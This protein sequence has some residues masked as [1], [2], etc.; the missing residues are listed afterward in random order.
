MS[1]AKKQTL[2]N[3]SGQMKLSKLYCNKPELFGPIEFN[4]GL[5]VVLAE[6]RLPKNKNKDTHN[7]GKTTLV[8]L[9]NFMLLAKR[10]SKFFLFK[11]RD[12]FDEFVFFLEIELFDNLYITVCRSVKNASKISFRK[13]EVGRQNFTDLPVTEWNH[14][15]VPFEK[16]S[17]ILDGLLDLRAFNPWSFRKGIGYLL[18]S[19]EDYRDVFQLRKF[20]GDH[21]DWKPFLA[22]LLGFNADLLTSYYAKEKHI[23]ENKT[24]ELVIKKEF[25]SSLEDISKIEGMLLLKQKEIEEQ[26][27]FLD[28]FDFRPQDENR[29]KQLVDQIDERIA[30]LNNE[31]YSLQK[32]KKKILDSLKEEQILFNP[33]EAQRLFAEAGVFFTGQIKKYFQQLITFNR[34]ITEERRAYLQEDMAEIENKLKEV[35]S[36]RNYLGKQRS[37]TLSFLSETDVFNKY[38]KFSNDLVVLKADLSS[39]ER[40]RDA[41]RILKEELEHLQ[42]AIE[43]DVELQ[44]SDKKSLFSTIRLFF[45]EIIEEVIDRKAL[46]NVA[47]NRKGHLEFKAEILDESGNATSADMGS[48]YRKLLCMAFDLAVLRSYFDKKFPRFVY[49]DGVFEKLEPRKKE[50][51]LNVIRRYSELGIQIVITSIDSDLPPKQDGKKQVF[52]EREIIL[53]L[54]DENEQG[55]LFRMPSW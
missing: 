25:G 21:S 39:L 31:R 17:D 12:L 34:A 50:N 29:T 24:N 40:Q 13:H 45:N 6:I 53:T 43:S 51:L 26:Q 28:S 2:L 49:H 10:D 55:R 19:Q 48:T 44:N 1:I 33:D 4:S 41:L 54:H 14:V 22:H 27:G 9:L 18:R 36:E 35:N 3:I 20:A 52:D 37:E 30:L 42:A 38:K 7:L 16:A 46:L 23:E 8:H 15:D 5:N 11:H 32:N 47:P